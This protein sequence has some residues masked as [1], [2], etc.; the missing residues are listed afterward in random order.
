YDLLKDQ[1]PEQVSRLRPLKGHL[2]NI[3]GELY[4][5]LHIEEAPVYNTC[6]RE[7]VAQYFDFDK[8]YYEDFKDAFEKLKQEY[9][10]VVGKLSEDSVPINAEIDMMFNFFDKADWRVEVVIRTLK[11]IMANCRHS[12]LQ[13]KDELEKHL[14]KARE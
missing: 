7:F 1:N 14:E 9:L 13:I 6:S 3:L 10:R 12:W 4:G 11:T 5:K 2:R 8:D